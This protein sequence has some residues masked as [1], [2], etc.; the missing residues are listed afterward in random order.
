M[1][2]TTS[3][4][5][6][7]IGRGAIGGAAILAAIGFLWG[8]WTTEG[9]HLDAVKAASNSAVVAALAPICVDSFSKGAN[10]TEQKAEMMKVSSWNRGDFIAKGGWATVPGT[11][12]PN[13]AVAKAC[14]EL[15]SK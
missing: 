8:G 2:R 4:R 1:D 7:D 15:L 3:D 12:A 5:A 14:A 11:T 6:W 9:K 13:S 10:A